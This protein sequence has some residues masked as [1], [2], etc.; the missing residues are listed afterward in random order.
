MSETTVPWHEVAKEQNRPT[1]EDHK[2]IVQRE[3]I[4]V[5]FVP[6]AMGSNLRLRG[7]NGTGETNG[8]KNL[9]WAPGD[10]M[11]MAKTYMYAGG[12]FRKRMLIGDV[13]DPDFL[14]PHD[15]T[16]VGDGFQSL[17]T[18]Y[19][20]NFIRPVLVDRDWAGALNDLFVFPVYAFGYNWSDSVKTNGEKLAKRIKEIIAEAKKVTGLCEKV[21]LITHSMGGLV[22]RCAA[23]LSGA[24]GDI[25]GIV[26]GVQP[27]LGATAA[28]WRIKAG[29]EGDWKMS[30]VLGNCGK[31]VTPLLGS[32][33]GGLQLLPTKQFYTSEDTPSKQWLRICDADGKVERSLPASD[34]YK[35]I[36]AV[37]AWVRPLDDKDVP[38]TNTYWGL[39]D[40]ELLDPDNELD[41]KPGKLQAMDRDNPPY[42]AWKAFRRQLDVAEALHDELGLK[43]HKKTLDI[44]GAGLTT[45]DVIE[46]RTESNLARSDSYPTRG[47]RG[48]FTAVDDRKWMPGKSRDM[49]AV[50]GEAKGRGDVTV[51]LA[52]GLALT[53]PPGTPVKADTKVDVRSGAVTPVEHQPAFENAAVQQ[54]TVRALQTLCADYYT[55]KTGRAL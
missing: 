36:Y 8:L 37:P 39:V 25:L 18:D 48:F 15:S 33:P 26:H 41:P 9:R 32:S 17:M 5:I 10:H 3:A 31:D 46:L 40:P 29:F 2:I 51:P 11:Y 43:K 7:T 52:S 55:E 12:S 21:I 23:K 44:A 27:V 45:A 4:P 13:F 24:E 20:N 35:E 1:T 30:A 22:S 50:L 53:E 42:D 47:F 16:P 38:S 19:V 28:Y 49:Q 54:W 6:G 14:E 34:P